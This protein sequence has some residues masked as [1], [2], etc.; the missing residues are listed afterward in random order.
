MVDDI[1]EQVP[2][3]AVGLGSPLSTTRDARQM[4]DSL[5]DILPQLERD[6]VR[7]LQW[8]IQDWRYISSR[9]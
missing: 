3:D 7:R 6:H 9:L 4:R 8:P 5:E 2:T 1:V